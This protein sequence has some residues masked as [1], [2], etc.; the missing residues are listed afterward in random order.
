MDMDQYLL[1]PFLGVN[2]YIDMVNTIYFHKF[3]YPIGP[4][5]GIYANIKGVY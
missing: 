5:Y 1:I 3:I 2:T 4:M